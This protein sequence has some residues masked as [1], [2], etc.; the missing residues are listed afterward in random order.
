MKNGYDPFVTLV[1]HK[2]ECVLPINVSR[3]KVCGNCH[4]AIVRHGTNKRL[5]NACDGIGC[6]VEAGEHA[7]LHPE[8]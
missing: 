7:V 1:L 3:H 8:H 4:D 2:H 6:L 5:E